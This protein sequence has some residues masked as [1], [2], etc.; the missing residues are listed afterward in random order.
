VGLTLAYVGDGNNVANS[1]V[2]GGTK[3]GMNIKLATPSR[4]RPSKDVIDAACLFAQES[5]GSIQIF[6]D[7]KEAVKDADVVYT[8]TG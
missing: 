3:L 8:D 1:L 2:F 5:G 6:D 7:P 4:Y